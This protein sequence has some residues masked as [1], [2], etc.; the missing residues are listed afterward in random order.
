M[1]ILGYGFSMHKKY[2]STVSFAAILF[3]IYI[4][5]KFKLATYYSFLTREKYSTN[6]RMEIHSKIY[7]VNNSWY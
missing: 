7:T 1:H 6:T 3:T 4:I 2:T 5:Y